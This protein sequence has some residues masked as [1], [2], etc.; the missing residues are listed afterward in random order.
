MGPNDTWECKHIKLKISDATECTDKEKDVEGHNC[1]ET[2]D[3]TIM[4]SANNGD[5]H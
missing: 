4:D 2:I 1:A 5:R 3:K